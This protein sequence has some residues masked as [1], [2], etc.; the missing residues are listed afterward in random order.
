MTNPFCSVHLRDWSVLQASVQALKAAPMTRERLRCEL[1]LRCEEAKT[2]FPDESRVREDDGHRTRAAWLWQL[3]ESAPQQRKRNR[4]LVKCRFV[5]P[6]QP[7][8]T[9]AEEVEPDPP[10]WHDEP[11]PR[12]CSRTTSTGA[13]R[14]DQAAAALS[15]LH[16]VHPLPEPAL[17]GDRSPYVDEP[18][19]N[20][21][22]LLRLYLLYRLCVL[23]W[24]ELLRGAP[25]DAAFDT[26]T[27][28]LA[29]TNVEHNQFPTS[30]GDVD[31]DMPVDGRATVVATDFFKLMCSAVDT[32]FIRGRLLEAGQP[33][34][35][36][37]A[38]GDALPELVHAVALRSLMA[39]LLRAGA[40][41]DQKKVLHDLQLMELEAGSWTPAEFVTYYHLTFFALVLT[42]MQPR[43]H[44]AVSLATVEARSATAWRLASGQELI[45]AC[46]VAGCF[47]TNAYAMVAM[48]W[49]TALI[50][51][52][53][54][55]DERGD[56]RRLALMLREGPRL[57]VEKRRITRDTFEAS[58]ASMMPLVGRMVAN[59]PKTER[60]AS[61]YVIQ[62]WRRP[63]DDVVRT[64]LLLCFVPCNTLEHKVLASVYNPASL[65]GGD[66]LLTVLRAHAAGTL[67]A[68]G[69]AW[70]AW[71]AEERDP[72]RLCLYMVNHLVYVRESPL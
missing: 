46:D 30:D 6:S 62:M 31:R 67:A 20:S 11:L 63:C 50:G 42:N 26:A 23:R 19:V 9:E 39:D 71:G 43:G 25:G 32:V 64:A 55:P 68:A 33:V 53:Q 45:R 8:T 7:R 35:A 61:L 2:F 24:R 36:Q 40:L 48:A 51:E 27:V 59:P 28:E 38:Y 29:F 13:I 72:L 37:E 49:A 57:S 52:E 17:F 34:S 14:A 60:E 12:W 22:Q 65:G 66:A 15:H 18:E 4:L 47:T 1:K 21:Y 16:S 58:I 56:I 44:H 41:P 10:V 5:E 54:W 3:L 70:E 69:S